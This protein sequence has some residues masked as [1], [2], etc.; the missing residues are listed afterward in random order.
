[1]EEC[2]VVI[3]PYILCCD[4]L[5]SQEPSVFLQWHC[6]GLGLLPSDLPSQPHLTSGFPLTVTSS[7]PLSKFYT[8]FYLHSEWLHSA[9]G[10]THTF[11]PRKGTGKLWVQLNCRFIQLHK[12]L[13]YDYCILDKVTKDV[14]RF[15]NLTCQV[16]CVCVC[17]HMFL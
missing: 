10:S 13:I 3:S 4:F 6:E 1:M 7:S 16:L 8:L 2:S 17:A 5:P 9:L 12:N 11:T 15:K 14:S